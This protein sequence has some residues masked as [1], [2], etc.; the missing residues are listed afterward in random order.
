MRT[1]LRYPSVITATQSHIIKLKSKYHL[2]RI[3]TLQIQYISFVDIHLYKYIKKQKSLFKK[4]Q[5]NT[6]AVPAI[7]GQWH[8]PSPIRFNH[9]YYLSPKFPFFFSNWI[10]INV[11]I[12]G[13][14]HQLQLAFLDTGHVDSAFEFILLYFIANAKGNNIQVKIIQYASKIIHRCSKTCSC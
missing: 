9:F 6:M 11:K 2:P 12:S 5:V 1:Q 14:A 13:H 4:Y 10:N 3:E 7:E 8:Q